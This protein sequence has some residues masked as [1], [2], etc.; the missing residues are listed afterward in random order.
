MPNIFIR[1][2]KPTN[3]KLGTQTKHEDPHHQQALDLQGQGR[4]KFSKISA[5]W[6]PKQLELTDDHK[7][8]RIDACQSLVNRYRK[9]QN[10]FLSS[11]ITCDETWVHYNSPE[12]K[13]SSMQW[14]HVARIFAKPKEIQGAGSVIACVFGTLRELF[15]WTLC[16]QDILWMQTITVH[17]CL[18]CLID[19]DQRSPQ[20][21][22]RFADE[23]CH[24]STWQ[25]T[26]TSTTR[27]TVEKIE[28]MSWE[29]LQHPPYSPDLAPSDFHLFG[30]LKE[31]LGGIKFENDED[32]Q[33]HV[34]QFLSAAD[35]EFYA[36]GFSQLVE[37]WKRCINSREIILKSNI[38]CAINCCCT[39]RVVSPGTYWT[40]LVFASSFS[41]LS[42][43]VFPAKL[44]RFKSLFETGMQT[45]KSSIRLC[46][47][48]WYSFIT[49]RCCYSLNPM[50]VSEFSPETHK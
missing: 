41:S 39:V 47:D 7:Q 31:F 34:I 45:D 14:K 25:Y 29:L 22:T 4:L 37:R 2:G 26:T 50:A 43:K 33:Q 30:P 23:R 16:L 35:K 1:T 32:V 27:R 11:I 10:E 40:P 12:S 49:N 42:C 6:V 15:L 36:A 24:S 5:R 20:K 13:R 21:A 28:E 46:M 18:N 48:H 19:C 9:E 8:Q 3:F 38:N 44:H 17:Y